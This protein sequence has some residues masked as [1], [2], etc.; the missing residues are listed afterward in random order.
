MTI[1]RLL[2]YLFFSE[3]EALTAALS[4]ITGP[5]LGMYGVP[6]A[7][8]LIRKQPVTLK[9]PYKLAR[10]QAHLSSFFPLPH[11]KR[12]KNLTLG[13]GKSV[14]L[15]LNQNNAENFIC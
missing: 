6:L 4:M 1:S 2:Y 10:H 9:L 8:L 7:I 5:F 15:P 3:L 11:Q 14:D 13:C 12:K